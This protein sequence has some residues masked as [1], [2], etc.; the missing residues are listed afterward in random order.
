MKP[1]KQWLIMCALALASA[2]GFTQQPGTKLW[3]FQTGGAIASSPAIGIDGAIYVG[4]EDGT[5]YAVNPDGTKKWDFPTGQSIPSSPCVGLDGI[6][7]FGCVDGK[8]YALNPNG[9]RKGDFQT[10]GGIFNTPAL[11]D[12]SLIYV[13]STD[14]KLYALRDGSGTL[15]KRWEFLLCGGG[16]CSPTRSPVIGRDG[17]IYLAA[18]TNFYAINR[19][20]TVK[21]AST[22]YQSPFSMSRFSTAPAIGDDGTLYIASYRG[23]ASFVHAFNPDGSPKWEYPSP[24]GVSGTSLAIGMDG[25]I[26][27]PSGERQWAHTFIIALSK[28]GELLWQYPGTSSPSSLR[29]IA[30]APTLAQDG[31]I[32]LSLYSDTEPHGLICAMNPGA[33]CKWQFATNAVITFSASPA[34]G[35]DGTVYVGADD[36]KLYAIKGDSPLAN[37]PWPMA[38]R[39]LRHD[40]R[41]GHWGTSPYLEN[42]GK[43]RIGNQRY[44]GFNLI[45]NPGS[46]Y[47][48]QASPDLASWTGLTNIGSSNGAIQFID[49]ATGNLSNRFYRAVAP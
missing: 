28:D 17:T 13:V 33:S 1:L 15:S 23:E 47:T 26:Y 35:A 32:Y 20:G 19:N 4:S 18:G 25:I 49:R 39:N 29:T 42:A 43:K 2:R 21:W 10:G 45:G 8:L 7:Y 3:D 48:I 41:A 31:S 46:N 16:D 40:G 27:V 12:D 44:F 36:G 11:D 38:G 37:S 24:V 30:S 22:S 34:I 9:T 14:S 5:L 6:I